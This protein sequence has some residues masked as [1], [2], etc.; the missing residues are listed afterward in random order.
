MASLVSSIGSQRTYSSAFDLISLT[1][2]SMNHKE[3][4]IEDGS[5]HLLE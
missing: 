3:R 4:M 2:V 5:V 1:V